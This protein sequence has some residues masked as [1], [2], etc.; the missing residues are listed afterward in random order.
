M[1]CQHLFSFL[2]GLTRIARKRVIFP[3]L[4]S[5]MRRENAA[6]LFARHA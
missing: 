3:A 4:Y 6:V 2:F 5:A 1:A